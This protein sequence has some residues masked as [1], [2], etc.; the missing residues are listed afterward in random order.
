[1][2]NED[3]SRVPS[4]PRCFGQCVHVEISDALM[5]VCLEQEKQI[6]AQKGLRN[7]STVPLNKRRD[8]IG[9][10]GQNGIMDLFQSY[11]MDGGLEFSP[12]FDPMR[13]GD[14]WDFRYRGTSYDIKS[15]PIRKYKWVSARTS[16]LVS[17]RQ[18]NKPV[19]GY[20]FCQ[21]DLENRIIHYAGVVEYNYFWQASVPAVGEW[22]RSPA[23]IIEAK[24][25]SPIGDIVV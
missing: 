14:E 1:M 24:E 20:V 23:H 4:T 10:L 7:P 19:D 9:S 15:S 5:E 21:V 3:V 22:V 6:L 13:H 2:Y 11:G 18:R 16:F 17:D 8:L 12:Y 25:L